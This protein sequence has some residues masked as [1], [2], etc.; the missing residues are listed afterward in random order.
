MF[1]GGGP[2]VAAGFGAPPPF[3]PRAGEQF[4]APTGRGGA[5]GRGGAPGAAGPAGA[6]GAAGA[7]ANAPAT[8]AAAPAAGAPTAGGAIDQQTFMTM[9]EAFRI[10]GKN[11]PGGFAALRFLSTLGFN[12]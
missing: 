9:I 3:N 10:P 4:A 11:Q 5:A 1:G 2:A 12:T 7:P 8:G 6:A